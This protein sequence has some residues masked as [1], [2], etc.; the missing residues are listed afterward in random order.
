[1]AQSP[2]KGYELMATGSNTDTWGQ[3]QN[4]D[5]YSVIDNN[6][7]GIVTKSLTN[8]NIVLT[9]DESQ[10]AILVL[11]GAMTGNVQITTSCQGFFFVDNQTTGSFV[12]TLRNSFVS[13]ST[14]AP[15]G[16]RVTV[17][18]DQTNGCRIAGA[19]DFPSGTRMAFQQTTVPTGW[20]K[21]TDAA[22]NDAAIKLTTGSVGTGGSAAFSS[23]FASLLLA[24]N[25]F[26]NVSVVVDITDPGHLHPTL[27]GSTAA[28]AAGTTAT[29]RRSGA[30][31]TGT[32][33]T[34]ITA[35]FQL[36]GGVSQVPINLA[37]KYAEFCIGVKN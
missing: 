11:T 26:P 12:V 16:S 2:Y 34:G 32:S 13:T 25:N 19:G 22:Y 8:V 3:V 21:I 10:N 4:D 20:T 31:N 36:N 17:I 35:A 27:Y 5:I 14:T 9:A 1:M 6:L 23:A 7:G 37:V 30:E 18:S 15:Q 33:F 28:V 29:V 24:R